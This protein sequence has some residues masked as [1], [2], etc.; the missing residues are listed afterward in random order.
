MWG[1]LSPVSTELV[2]EMSVEEGKS[3]EGA[4]QDARRHSAGA[5]GSEP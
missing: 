4:R 5:Q 2:R 1:A 3:W